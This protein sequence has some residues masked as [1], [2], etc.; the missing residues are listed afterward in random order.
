MNLQI[1][2]SAKLSELESFFLI[3]KK[4]SIQLK[5]NMNLLNLG[6]TEG[7]AK[8]FDKLRYQIESNYDE[9]YL[10]LMGTEKPC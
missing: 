4:I 6:L 9:A 2:A 5:N 1:N 8:A 7:D 10:E 3:M